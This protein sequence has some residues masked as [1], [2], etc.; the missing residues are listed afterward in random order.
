MKWVWLQRE[1]PAVRKNRQRKEE[2]AE[3]EEKKGAFLGFHVSLKG[4]IGFLC[5][6]QG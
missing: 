3:K 1:K 6:F 2:E 5:L 4:N